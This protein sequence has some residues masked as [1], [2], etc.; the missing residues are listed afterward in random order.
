MPPK[1]ELLKKI[2]DNESFEPYLDEDYN[3]LVLVDLYFTWS[4]P[5]EAMKE[6]Y[7]G[8]NINITGFADRCE[9]LQVKHGD[10]KF[11]DSYGSLTRANFE[12]DFPPNLERQSRERCQRRQRYTPFEI[13]RKT[14]SSS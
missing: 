13:L 1:R 10:V 8:L 3:K 9:I 11:F 6:Y 4:G 12:T 7:K 5:C 2:E 14:S